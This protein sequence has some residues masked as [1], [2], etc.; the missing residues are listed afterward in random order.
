MNRWRV[1]EDRGSKEMDGCPLTYSSTSVRLM[2]AVLAQR[3]HGMLAEVLELSSEVSS[4]MN[5]EAAA[6]EAEAAE[7][8][9]KA[10]ATEV[11]AAE[12]EGQITSSNSGFIVRVE[13]N[14]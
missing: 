6:L 7:V 8:A 4:V 10:E 9:T 12:T 11:E 2:S 14:K 5:V 1:G 13:G 3:P